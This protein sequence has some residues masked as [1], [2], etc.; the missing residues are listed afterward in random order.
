MFVHVY[1]KNES[2]KDGLHQ[3]A[4]RITFKSEDHFS[5]ITEPV[6]IIGTL[7]N[8]TVIRMKDIRWFWIE[9]D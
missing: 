6:L 9:E 5:F 2:D 1:R 4:T 8:T 3:S 7:P